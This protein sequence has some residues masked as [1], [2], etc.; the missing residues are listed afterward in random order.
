MKTYVVKTYN[1]DWTYKETINPNNILNEIAFSASL[2]WWQWQLQIQTDYAFADTSYK[3]W[4][5][6]KV[7][8]YDENHVNGKQIY[9]WFISK[10]ERKADQSRE[11]ILHLPALSFRRLGEGAQIEF[12]RLDFFNGNRLRLRGDFHPIG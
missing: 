6:V 8:L 7:W 5:Y 12:E 3:W 4:E 11:Y 1:I 9:Y 10:I 2:N